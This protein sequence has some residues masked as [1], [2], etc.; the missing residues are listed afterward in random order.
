MV[1]SDFLALRLLITPVISCGHCTLCL[2]SL[3]A[4][5]YPFGILWSLYSLS[6][7]PYGFWLP[8][9]YIVVI[10]LSVFLALWLLITPLVS[11]GHCTLCLLSLTA[12]D[13]PFDILW[14]LYCLSS[15]PYGF[16]L[17]LWYLVDILLSVFLVWRLLITP[18]IFCG[19][20]TVCHLSL[21]ATDYPFGIL[22]SLY[23]LSSQ[24]YGFWLP[25]WYLVV[26]LLSV[27]LVWRLLITP[28]ISCGQCTLC[29]LSFTASSDHPVGILWSLYSLSSQPYGFWLPLWYIVVIVLSVFLSLRLVITSLIYRG[30]CTV[31][32]LSLTASDYLHGILWS[33]YS[34]SS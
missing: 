16:W 1:L 23:S 18:L 4:S 17:P 33:L 12:S 26:I 34:Q 8:L 5:D 27:F 9:W 28:L 25:L 13:Y 2:L 32:L 21:T 11:C 3:T 14:S 31:C 24:P 15:Q 10:V 20:C 29:L 19:H 6:S 7:Q 30:H 22:W